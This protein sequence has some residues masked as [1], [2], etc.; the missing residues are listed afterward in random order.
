[1]A[2]VFLVLL[3]LLGQLVYDGIGRVSWQFLTSYPSRFPSQAGILS[4]WI[5]TVLVMLLTALA[6]LP[7]G[8]GAA[9]YLE[10]YAPKN[11]MTDL[12]EINIANLAGV[13]S[14][15]YGL[16]AL[17]LLVYE[18]HL[19]QSFLTAGLT[20]AML[21]L[22]IVIIATREALRAV[23]PQIREA[24]YAVG[25]TKWQTVRD[26]VV[27]YS[28]GGM[29]TGMI[30]ALSRAVGETA[31]LI[32]VGALSFIAFLPRPPLTSEFPFISI[33]WLFDPFTVMPIQMFNW[34]SRPQEEFHF[35][36]AA[37]GLILLVMTLA[38]NALAI[39]IRARFRRRIHW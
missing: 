35:N 17:G 22:P 20:L 29:L 3:A 12:I 27:P 1:M 13:P 28:M 16:M 4:A 21:I 14:I 34:V 25:A 31:P 23:P 39:T 26:H 19:G 24:A 9:I 36:A 37:A 30:L 38:M 32:T 7:L 5:G 18:F 2:G 10:E 15:V 6:A 8:V 11:W 33:Q